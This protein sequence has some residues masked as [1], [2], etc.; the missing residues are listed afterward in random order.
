[1]KI[2]FIKKD[3]RLIPYSEKDRE[4]I[5]KFKDGSVYVVDV[6]NTSIRTLQQNKSIHLWCSQIATALNANNMYIKDTIKTEVSWSMDTVK[7]ILFKP[8]V[9]ALYNKD[10]TTK[11]DKNEFEKIIDTLTL[12]FANRG[13]TLPAFPNRDKL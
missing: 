9:K 5:D 7:E 13:V 8:I 1:M 2:N 6:K 3:G 10:S 11:L 4:L 12:I